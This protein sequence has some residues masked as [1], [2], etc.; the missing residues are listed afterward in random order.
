[1]GKLVPGLLLFKGICG[2]AVS[3]P[4]AD[5]WWG[6]WLRE[7]WLQGMGWVC[8]Y[9]LKFVYR[10]ANNEH[11]GCFPAPVTATKAKR[12][13]L[14]HCF[15]EILLHR[16]GEDLAASYLA[17]GVCDIGFSHCC[18]A[19]SQARTGLVQ[20]SSFNQNLSPPPNGCIAFPNFQ[21]R[22][23]RTQDT[24][25]RD[26]SRFQTTARVHQQ[27]RWSVL[28]SLVFPTALPDW[29]QWPPGALRGSSYWWWPQ[30]QPLILPLWD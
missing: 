29:E 14:P 22:T 4:G 8:L 21:L 20:V 13:N 30:G 25:C 9:T 26:H 19:G 5:S 1:M 16:G 10:D 15:R 2:S 24:T 11:A 17:V 27:Q 7:C 28:Q 23:E 12:D 3:F 18:W 6:Q